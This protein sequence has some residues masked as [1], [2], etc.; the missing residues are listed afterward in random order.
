MSEDITVTQ[1]DGGLERRITTGMIVNDRFLRDI[2]LIYSSDYMLIPFAKTVASWCLSYYKQYQKAPGRHIRDI[3]EV[4]TKNGLNPDQADLIATFLASISEEYENSEQLNVDYLLTQAENHFKQQS[5]KALSDDILA[6]V[7]QG[8]VKEAEELL[9]QFKRV[10]RPQSK[11]INPFT[12]KEAIYRAVEKREE[13]ILFKLPGAL[14][15]FLGPIERSTF[16]GILAPEKRGKTWELIQ[17]GINAY[18]QRCNVA[19]FEI[20]DMVEQDIVRRISKN[21]TK[22][23]TENVGEI[24]VPVLDCLHNQLNTCTKKERCCD[25]G[26]LHRKRSGSAEEEYDKSTLE[27]SPNYRPCVACNSQASTLGEFKG[28][29]WHKMEE[30]TQLNW[31]QSW[32]IGQKI[33]K[34]AQG[35]DFKL[36]CL[37]NGSLSVRGIEAQLNMWEQTE[38]F[39]P[40][41]LIIDY[42]DNLS[43]IDPKREERHRQNDNWKALRALSQKYFCAVI[44]ATQADAASYDKNSLDES[45]FSEA[46]GKYGQVTSFWTL[47]QTPE[48][49]EQGIIR[50][51]QMMRREGKF[52]TN[53]HCTVLQCLDIGR[54]YMG[55]FL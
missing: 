37:P 17:L 10:E 12:N 51:G 1:F 2:Q 15:H 5:L 55:S 52:D 31:R 53:K 18:Q 41:V 4:E 8:E 28:A 19:F 27:E 21:T 24:K 47:N 44:T 26:V 20:G 9:T 35:K 22:T 54:P 7:S 13:N 43:P 23:T 6:L 30:I 50:I 38:G 11:G 32:E 49:K 46:K 39:I 34:R 45:N 33:A 29:V 36:V 3:F 16:T 40:D 25:F 42:A 14:G 48:E